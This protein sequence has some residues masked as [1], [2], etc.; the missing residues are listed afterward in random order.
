M[1]LLNRGRKLFYLA[2]IALLGRRVVIRVN[3][4]HAK[5]APTV[6]VYSR[7]DK[8]KMVTAMLVARYHDCI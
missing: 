8:L 7:I 4:G 2:G 6:H 5:V 1:S 3:F